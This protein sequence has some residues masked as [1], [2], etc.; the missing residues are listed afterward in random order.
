MKYGKFFSIALIAVLLFG[1]AGKTVYVDRVVEVPKN[2]VQ[3]P[4][5]DY[6]QELERQ[7]VV[8]AER[9]RKQQLDVACNNFYIIYRASYDAGVGKDEG[10][11]VNL[12]QQIFQANPMKVA[13]DMNLKISK[14][15]GLACIQ[16][17]RG[18]TLISYTEFQEI[19]KQSFG[20]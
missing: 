1:C 3:N 16:G 4:Q 14:F 9:A 7:R 19:F 15:C 12:A 13:E 8:E 5:P 18:Q 17:S 10:F 6:N 11:C 20:N 2:E